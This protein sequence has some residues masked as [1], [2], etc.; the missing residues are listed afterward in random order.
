MVPFPFV[1]FDTLLVHAQSG[2]LS[3]TAPWANIHDVSDLGRYLSIATS[4][5]SSF[6]NLAVVGESGM[7]R[8]LSVVLVMLQ[9]NMIRIPYKTATETPTVMRPK[10][11]KIICNEVSNFFPQRSLLIAYLVGFKDRR[12]DVTQAISDQTSN[13]RTIS[14]Q[15]EFYHPNTQMEL[16]MLTTPFIAYQEPSL[17]G[18][19]SRR[20]HIC[21]T[22]MNAGA[23]CSKIRDK[24]FFII[25]R[26]TY[27][28]LPRRY[29]R[30][31]GKPTGQQSYWRLSCRTK[32]YPRA[33]LTQP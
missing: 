26:W 18:C 30:T 21:V 17:T 29:L 10:N 22:A 33:G 28:C 23:G 20:Y 19:S 14:V 11:R 25:R 3:V 12:L 7:N 5:S 2:Y 13:L 15:S 1:A 27:Q 31:C 8:L 32:Q 9:A 16:T 4:L 6:R 24:A